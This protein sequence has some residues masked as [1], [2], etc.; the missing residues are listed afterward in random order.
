MK[1]PTK[2]A[3]I[4]SPSPRTHI[5]YDAGSFG[6][7]SPNS[8]PQTPPQKQRSMTRGTPNGGTP[9]IGYGGGIRSARCSSAHMPWWNVSTETTAATNPN[10]A[11]FNGAGILFSPVLSVQPEFDLTS[12]CIVG[13]CDRRVIIAEIAG[14]ITP[15]SP[16]LTE[17]SPRLS[18]PW[19][20]DCQTGRRLDGLRGCRG[21]GCGT[22][23]VNGVAKRSPKG[24]ASALA[25]EYGS[26]EVACAKKG[27]EPIPKMPSMRR[28]SPSLPIMAHLLSGQAKAGERVTALLH[29][30]HPFN[31][32]AAAAMSA[33]GPQ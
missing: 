32:A 27:V 11:R 26:I 17:R 5:G 25:D 23:V 15:D 21:D 4:P 31:R 33:S 20:P 13:R 14:S 22:S 10:N 2:A 8:A 9:L 1:R 16:D 29:Y 28:W 18:S 19:S 24:G 6:R 7:A 3:A 30:R 12:L